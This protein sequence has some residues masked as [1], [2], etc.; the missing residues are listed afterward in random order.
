[1]DEL[2]LLFSSRGRGHG[3]S[4]E[5]EEES[6]S[7]WLIELL[8]LRRSGA[9]SLRYTTIP[10]VPLEP[11][12]PTGLNGYEWQMRSVAYRRPASP[13]LSD[14]LWSG[15]SWLQGEYPEPELKL[16][17]QP[18]H[19]YLA[20]VEA[21]AVTAGDLLVERVVKEIVALPLTTLGIVAVAGTWCRNPAVAD[22]A[23]FCDLALLTFQQE[24]RDTLQESLETRRQQFI[25]KFQ[26][27]RSQLSASHPAQETSRYV[28]ELLRNVA[29]KGR[30]P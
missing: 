27:S 3:L 20:P 11:T 1:M 17:R 24:A 15:F 28:E 18:P 4:P 25:S 19:L 5:A 14:L 22:P 9:F 30:K 29:R 12:M 23:N 13:E 7:R 26:E 10:R 6:T 8:A 2:Q 21:V 16:S